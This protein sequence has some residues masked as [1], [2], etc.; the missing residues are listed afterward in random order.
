MHCGIAG[1]YAVYVAF[2]LHKGLNILE[3]CLVLSVYYWLL[4]PLECPTGAIADVYGRRIAVILSNV[5]LILSMLVFAFTGDVLGFIAA[6]ALKA[7]G[8]TYANGALDSYI[9]DKLD[10]RASQLMGAVFKRTEV[11]KTWCSLGA[12][13]VGSVLADVHMALPWVMSTVF[14]GAALVAAFWMKEA[15]SRSVRFSIRAESQQLIGTI[16]EGVKLGRDENMLVIILV[17]AIF[18]FATMTPNVLWQPY[19]KQWLPY[20]SL[21]GILWV[22]ASLAHLLGIWAA[23]KLR[24]KG[25]RALV[26][27]AVVVGV[28]IALTGLFYPN[29]PI[30]I[31]AAYL[32][33]QA[34]R[35]P[36]DPEKKACIYA[37]IRNKSV[38]ATAASFVSMVQHVVAALGLTLTG[39]VAHYW[40]MPKAF[41][42]AGLTMMC[43][44]YL[45]LGKSKDKD[46]AHDD[47]QKKD[48]SGDSGSHRSRVGIHVGAACSRTPA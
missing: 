16:R 29:A 27:Y 2:L 32:L 41:I 43:L 42:G 22:G 5:F 18:W 14:F 33:H 31:L 7:V 6:V 45:L 19:A 48:A 12:A 20:Q 35:G 15:R 21:L 10:G 26:Q 39:I 44:A 36:F 34:A 38:R 47:K 1:V 23:D 46:I 3:S 40:S 24:M 25:Q 17:A 13:M 11:L 4:A 9:A 37:A 8:R 30:A 28:C